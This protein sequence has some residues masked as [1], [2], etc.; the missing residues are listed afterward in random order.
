MACEFVGVSSETGR[1]VLPGVGLYEFFDDKD[2]RIYLHDMHLVDVSFDVA[3]PPTLTFHFR[4]MAR[5][6][7]QGEINIRCVDAVIS[8]LCTE[9]PSAG[10]EPGLV[11]LF[12]WDGEDGFQFDA[13]SLLASFSASRVEVVRL[14]R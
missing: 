11:S 1:G 12:D 7:N 5:D 14:T 2:R 3:P 8:E 13:D 4:R 9:R 10:Y 6:P